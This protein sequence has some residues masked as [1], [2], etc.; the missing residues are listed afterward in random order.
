M[1]AEKR[2]TSSEEPN[3]AKPAKK[4]KSFPPTDAPGKF[5][6][7][8]R[9][10]DCHK[11]PLIEGGKVSSNTGKVCPAVKSTAKL[12]VSEKKSLG[13]QKR[14]RVEETGKKPSFYAKT[15]KK[16]YREMHYA[17]IDTNKCSGNLPKDHLETIEEMINN[18]ILEH[19]MEGGYPVPIKSSGIG[20]DKMF[21]MLAAHA[22]SRPKEDCR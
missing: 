9:K 19:I 1:E 5:S 4:K 2:I 17:M 13:Q 16:P 12:R 10:G 20:N 18:K 21:F 8:P 15:A 14:K 3:T 7:I 22:H 6:Q 11:N